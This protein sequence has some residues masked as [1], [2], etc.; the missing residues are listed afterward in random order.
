MSF[1]PEEQGTEKSNS[2]DVVDAIL[3]ACDVL[4][5]WH[6]EGELLR[7]RDITERVSLR[8]T[9]AHRVLRSLVAGGMIER[10]SA[11]Q[12]RSLLRPLVHRKRRIGYASQA[13][14]STFSAIV[15][16]SFVR[17]AAE[18]NVDLQIVHNHYSGGRAAIRNADN[19]VRDHVDL[20]IEFQTYENVAPAVA[21]RFLETGI[22]VV[23][24][25]VPHPGAIY[26]GANNYQAGL[27]GG[28]ALGKWAK[29]N[30]NGNVDHL[31]ILEEQAAGPLPRSRI[32]GMLNG[33][34]ELLPSAENARVLVFDGKGSFEQSMNVVRKY[35]RAGPAKRA[36]V[37]A[38]NDS[39]ALGALRAFEEGGRAQYCAVMGQNGI[40]EAR[41]ELRRKGS[42]LVGTVAYFPERYGDEVIPLALSILGGKT[43]P[44]AVFVKHRLLVPAN[45]DSL[46]PL[47]NG[48]G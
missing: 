41:Q 6:Y 10:A 19:L 34:R 45:V 21:N 7:L 44:P 27:I 9:T 15:S 1:R 37:M 20:V 23:A 4:R 42:R 38:G 43:L 5:A 48:G 25:E 28:R 30:W 13:Q 46:Y 39:S 12:Y 17:A 16:E 8:K 11:E 40:P 24:L 47:D 3:R 2:G 31:L 36:L 22:P 18:H 26:F 33:V 29:D 35:L 14:N 32:T